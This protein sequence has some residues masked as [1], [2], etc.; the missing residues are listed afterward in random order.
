MNA[1]V[2]CDSGD[3]LFVRRKW[4][5]PLVVGCV[6]AV[7]SSVG[8]WNPSLW[9]DEAAT[10]SV[11]TRT[12]SQILALARHLDAVHATYYL[13]MHVWTGILGV[14]PWAIRLPSVLAVGI[15]AVG[16][17]VLGRQVSTLR[18]GVTAGLLF[19]IL[20]RMTWAGTEARS[21]AMVAML[22]VWLTVALL[23]AV[24]GA[25]T[26]WILY[27]VLAAIGVVLFLYLALIVVA[28]GLSLAAWWFR[29]QQSP[30]TVIFWAAASC[31]AAALTL[32]FVLATVRQS[33]HV[34]QTRP[35]LRSI[36][37]KVG[38]FQWFHDG[39]LPDRGAHLSQYFHLSLNWATGAIALAL[40]CLV[41][42]GVG[43]VKAGAPAATVGPSLVE[44]TV[45]WIVL[46]TLAVLVFSREVSPLY[47]PR[48][49][50]GSTPAVALLVAAGLLS[51]RHRS[52]TAVTVLALV[53]FTAPVYLDQRTGTAKARSDWKYAAAVIGERA[54]PGDVVVFGELAHKAHQTTRKIAIAYPNDFIGLR[55][56]T[57]RRSALEREALW[58]STRPLAEV[59]DDVHNARRVWL[60]SDGAAGRRWQQRRVKNL[61][62]LETV[63]Y[64]PTWMWKGTVTQID[65]LVLGVDPP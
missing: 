15:A 6:G 33:G 12:V 45:P 37:T 10:I 43:I 29:T 25:V 3:H 51:L 23:L 65:E 63:G 39:G 40:L 41:L 4:L 38:I 49:M 20:P 19:A 60:V 27:G 28:H 46:P 55:D 52:L 5:A 56:I 9:T 8:Y 32:P 64:R 7:I 1:P 30:R 62:I 31:I 35:R 61:R 59:A 53:V 44:L 48:Y 34:H 58:P 50:I 17:V 21:F 54:R 14:A 22:A 13:F 16:V 42:I 2:G 36:P 57:V 26:W 24:R 47:T 18:F 11:S